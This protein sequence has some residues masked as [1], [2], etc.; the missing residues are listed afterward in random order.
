MN[1]RPGKAS[2]VWGRGG[3]VRT[4]FGMLAQTAD[5]AYDPASG[6]FG[7][8]VVGLTKQVR[9]IDSFT[10]ADQAELDARDL[11]L[12]SSS[13]V[14]FPFGNRTLVAT[15]GKESKIYLLDAKNLG[16]ADHR[17]PLYRSERW[18]NDAM[19]FGYNGMWGVMST[20]V[21]AQGKRWLLAPMYGPPAKNTVGLFK[22]S[23]GNVINGSLMAFTVE[24]RDGKPYL[25][26]EWISGDLDL[27]GVAVIANGVIFALANARR[28]IFFGSA[29]VFIF[30]QP[31][32]RSSRK[33]NQ[34]PRF[35]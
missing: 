17:T 5:G 13:P 34:F 22:K 35:V 9:L 4:P 7:G 33:V 29:E 11:E 23:H 27:P 2:G 6:R 10:P 18:A 8:S 14:V 30:A 25:A 12:G 20:Y 1:L 31:V 24:S 15:A 3:I 28:V 16:G 26:P 21:D 32:C 19:A